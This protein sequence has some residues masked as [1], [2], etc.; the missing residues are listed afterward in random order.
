M[1]T[2][3]MYVHHKWCNRAPCQWD[4]DPGWF[5]KRTWDHKG[6]CWCE[7]QSINTCAKFHRFPIPSEGT[8]AERLSWLIIKSL[9]QY[10]SL[11]LHLLMSCEV[12]SH[13]ISSY[14]KSISST[15][16]GHHLLRNTINHSLYSVM[17]LYPH[18]KIPLRWIKCAFQFTACY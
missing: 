5:V 10:N 13:Y 6:K 12:K 18:L 11:L 14:L 4:V 1:H 2:P 3:F 16:Q 7:P 17:F 9:L 15:S 8:G